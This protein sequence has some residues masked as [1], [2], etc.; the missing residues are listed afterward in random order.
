MI[1]LKEELFGVTNKKVTNA[2]EKCDLVWY[3]RE[4]SFRKEGLRWKLDHP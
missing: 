2:V 3:T 1:F 4:R